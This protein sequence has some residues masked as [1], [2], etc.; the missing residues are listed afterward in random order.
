MGIYNTKFL[1]SIPGEIRCIFEV[2]LQVL[3]KVLAQYLSWSNNLQHYIHFIFVMST[4]KN[5]TKLVGMTQRA[6]EELGARQP[7]DKWSCGP[8]VIHII[9]QTKLTSW[10][11][12]DW[13]P[14]VVAREARLQQAITL[15]AI[16]ALMCQIDQLWAYKPDL[17][18]YVRE[19]ANLH[20]KLSFGNGLFVSF[21]SSTT[22]RQFSFITICIQ[23]YLIY[24]I[25]TL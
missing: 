3:L 19:N 24:F 12:Q 16:K 14:F 9:I 17:L 21:L 11:P 18:S 15:L 5:I 23:D 7:F 8:P 22:Y 25:I 10:Y 2:L 6:I 4:T 13:V 1:G 20:I